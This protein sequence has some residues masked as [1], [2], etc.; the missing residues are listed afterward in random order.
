MAAV[1]ATVPLGRVA[2]PADVGDAVAWLVSDLARFVS[3][4]NLV[5]Q[6]GGERLA[7]TEHLGGA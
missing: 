2:E 4:S 6:G 1:E 5:V 7:F 3:G